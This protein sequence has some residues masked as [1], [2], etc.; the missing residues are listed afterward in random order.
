M[1]LRIGYHLKAKFWTQATKFLFPGYPVQFKSSN[2]G[3]PDDPS[4]PRQLL[5]LLQHYYSFWIILRVT[6]SEPFKWSSSVNCRQIHVNM[7]LLKHGIWYFYVAAFWYRIS[8]TVSM[9]LELT[10]LRYGVDTEIPPFW[11]S[12]LVQTTKESAQ[13]LLQDRHKT[14]I[15]FLPHLQIRKQ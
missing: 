4:N 3:G 5:T 11:M 13:T 7:A 10:L 12:S 8:P 9:F 1:V 2:L 6:H 15:R 14:L